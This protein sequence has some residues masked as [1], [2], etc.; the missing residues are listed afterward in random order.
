MCF[1]GGVASDFVKKRQAF[2]EDGQLAGPGPLQLAVDADDVAQVEALRQGEVRIAD[3]GLADHDLDRAGPVA[4][5][6]PVDLARRAAEHDAAGRANR[7]A[8]LLGRLTG[9]TVARRLDR[10]FPFASPNLADGLMP[11]EAL[12]PRVYSQFLYFAQFIAASRFERGFRAGR[13]LRV[14]VVHTRTWR[15]EDKA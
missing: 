13:L 9:R 1:S 8:V 2:G 3:L 14:G 5:L 7:G 11:V 15:S 12:P 10:D 6:E 4:N